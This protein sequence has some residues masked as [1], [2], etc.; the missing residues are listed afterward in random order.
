MIFAVPGYIKDADLGFLAVTRAFSPSTDRNWV[1]PFWELPVKWIFAAMPF[2]FLITIL[3]YFDVSRTF[4]SLGVSSTTD[5]LDFAEQCVVLDGPVARVPGQAACRVP[6][7][8]HRYQLYF[9]RGWLGY[10]TTAEAPTLTSAPPTPP[11]QD[12]FLLGCTTFVSGVLGLPA[13]N[14]LVPQAPVHTE[15]LCELKA[16]SE[17]ALL[18]EGGYYDPDATDAEDDD[19]DDV[20]RPDGDGFALKVVRTRVV[21]QRVSAFAMGLLALGT[22]TGPLLHVLGLMP[23]ALFSGIFLVVGWA[24]IEG[25]PILHRTLF[26]LRDP[27]LTPRAHPLRALRRSTIVRFVAIQWAFFAAIV[28]VS[29]TLAGIAF[30]LIII[31]LVPVRHFVLPRWFTADELGMLDDPTA[32]SEA[33]LVSLGGPLQGERVREARYRAGDGEAGLGDGGANYGKEGLRRRRGAAEGKEAD[34]R[35]GRGVEAFAGKEKG[36]A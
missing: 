9:T 10:H 6:L 13:P 8:K 23:K 16:V 29:Y 14:G 18:S 17:R 36:G 22:M 21:E 26:L 30:P 2:G 25:N 35:G 4:D 19:E 27:G 34:G 24:S 32:T 33:V 15:A 7:G 11:S 5:W 31:M 3:F 28:A 12:F 1:V 20:A